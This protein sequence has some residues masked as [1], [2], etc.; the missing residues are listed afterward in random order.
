M[1]DNVSCNNCIDSSGCIDCKNCIN[2]SACYDC[3]DCHNCNGCIRLY[4]SYNCED[5]FGARNQPLEYYVNNVYVGK[6][7]FKSVIKMAEII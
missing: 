7:R 1:I 2:C 4:N 3:V 6:E 5:L